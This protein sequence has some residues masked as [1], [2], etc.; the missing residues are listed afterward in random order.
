MNTHMP[1]P[2][3][4]TISNLLLLILL[5]LSSTPA[6]S[7]ELDRI[8]AIVN[9]HVI[10]E[11]EL[12][13]K[14]NEIQAQLARNQTSLPPAAVLRRQVLERLILTDLQLQLAALN[15]IRADDEMV[16]SA[17][18]RIAQ[19]NGMAYDQF[20]QAVAADGIP[21]EVFR[22]DVRTQIVINRLQQRQI[23]NDIV[24]TDDEIERFL[25]A[26][27][28]DQFEKAEF[29]L[30]HILIALT[31]GASPKEV[32]AGRKEAE[33][34]RQELIE[35]ADFKSTAVAH[36]DGQFALEGG[37]LGW[38]RSSE[39]P[40]LFA[41]IVQEMTPG[42]ISP[43]IR[44]ASGFHIVTLLDAKVDT[45]RHLVKQT[46][47][48]HILIESDAIT[49]DQIARTRLQQL[50]ERIE[51]GEDFAELAKRYSA[52]KGS[53][54]NGGDLGWVNEGDLVPTFEEQMNLLPINEISAPFRTQY[55]WHIVQILERR[56]QDNT[57]EYRRVRAANILR[58]Q[59]YEEALQAWLNNLRNEAY[60]E[61]RL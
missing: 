38:R 12:T 61:V 46:R 40:S 15:N 24:V 28:T 29:R 10:T 20:V 13:T 3:R 41:T 51:L 31:E 44:S 56:E 58:K 9:D 16:N 14:V 34:L 19:Q 45:N 23:A 50:R 35:G 27:T 17:I 11:T 18:E 33:D 54:T 6:W 39:I 4:V 32:K 5:V 2:P 1:F 47:A 22:E 7:K 8:V 48:R 26:W 42:D 43:L 30:G 21:F 53:A 59:K 55:G 36:S 25:E 49:S 37:D 52:D 57:E 60:V